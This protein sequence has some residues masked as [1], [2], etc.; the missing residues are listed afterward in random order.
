MYFTKGK[1]N[2]E[3]YNLTILESQQVFPQVGSVEPVAQFLRQILNISEDED[4]TA[5]LD[6]VCQCFIT[7]SKT[8]FV[9]F[10]ILLC[11]HL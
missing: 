10:F 1:E 2:L 3:S 6:N 9:L 7:L 4:P 11:F 8:S 5:F